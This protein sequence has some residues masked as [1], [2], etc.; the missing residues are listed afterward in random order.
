[1]ETDEPAVHIERNWGWTVTALVL[2]HSSDG[3]TYN[4]N[5]LPFACALPLNKYEGE[6]G[7][8]AMEEDAYINRHVAFPGKV[9][10]KHKILI[11]I[12]LNHLWWP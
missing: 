9:L 5:G 11:K 2:A 1:M 3:D 8:I 4:S 7:C 12:E 6:I 10:N